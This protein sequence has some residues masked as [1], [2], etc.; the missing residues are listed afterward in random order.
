MGVQHGHRFD[1]DHHNWMIFKE[2][3]SL[4]FS[5]MSFVIK[6]K[7]EEDDEQFKKKEFDP[8]PYNYLINKST[9]F[10]DS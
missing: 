5:F 1:G 8:M 10:I 9:A 6:N 7:I 4:A 2:Y 3:I